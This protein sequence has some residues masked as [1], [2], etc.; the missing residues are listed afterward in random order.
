MQ[1]AYP[2]YIY[3]KMNSLAPTQ[4]NHK[5]KHIKTLPE[6]HSIS[7]KT[8]SV[9][10]TFN[11]SFPFLNLWPN[12]EPQV[13]T[14]DGLFPLVIQSL[15]QSKLRKLCHKVQL[16]LHCYQVTSKMPMASYLGE[17]KQSQI[18]DVNYSCGPKPKYATGPESESNWRTTSF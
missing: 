5:N 2:S 18:R 12:P 1:R 15:S 13:R 3:A 8:L 9:A 11:F 14:C 7:I 17:H 10:V 16:F 6:Q 4:I